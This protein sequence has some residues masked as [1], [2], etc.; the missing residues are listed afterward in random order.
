M[1]RAK[2][3]ETDPSPEHYT[4][5]EGLSTPFKK[6]MPSRGPQTLTKNSLTSKAYQSRQECD[7]TDP[8]PEHYT[9]KEGLS[10]LFK[11]TMPSKE[12][13]HRKTISH[14]QLSITWD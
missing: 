13:H 11:K 6:T 2:S 8:S 10:T 9:R 12:P 14:H 4:R 7:E 3:V 5:K 1:E